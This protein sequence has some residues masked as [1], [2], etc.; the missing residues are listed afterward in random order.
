M[1]LS[2]KLFLAGML[3]AAPLAHA[4]TLSPQW[5]RV[6]ATRHAPANVYFKATYLDR[7]GNPHQQEVWRQGSQR[8]RRKTD[9]R[10][11][12]YVDKAQDGD[13]RYQLVD[14][15]RQMLIHVNR[16]NLYRIGVFSD[17]AGLAHVVK[18][19]QATYRLTRLERGVEKTANGSCSWVGLES[20][21]PAKS[22]NEI[23]WSEK[24]GLP[25]LIRA[26]NRGGQ[27]VNQFTMQDIHTFT[28]KAGIFKVSRKGLMEIDANEEI[29]PQMD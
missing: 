6:F 26:Q 9:T 11:D 16:T 13:Y 4:K 27:W 15:T 14:H 21:A 25:L 19:P 3:L 10:L 24:W 28:P 22:V 29:D 20:D 8:L 1:K 7:R 5:D 2:Q 18:A 12:L 23:C 17:W